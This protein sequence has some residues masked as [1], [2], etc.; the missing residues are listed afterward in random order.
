MQVQGIHHHQPNFTNGKLIF[1]SKN[2]HKYTD[3]VEQYFP[4]DIRHLL[5]G[6]RKS[7]EGKPYDVYLSRAKKQPEFIEVAVNTGYDKA[8]K[9]IAAGKI[10]RYMVHENIVGMALEDTVKSATEAYEKIS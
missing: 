3:R 2:G 8:V 1:V 4:S 5:D 9:A 10:K 7:I 6:I